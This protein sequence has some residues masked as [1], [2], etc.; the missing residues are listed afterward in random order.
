MVR[1]A[2]NK[3]SR[4]NLLNGR[5]GLAAGSLRERINGNAEAMHAANEIIRRAS[6][7]IDSER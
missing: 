4:R 5:L 1:V 2:N 6:A 3:G 7:R